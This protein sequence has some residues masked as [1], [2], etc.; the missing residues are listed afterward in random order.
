MNAWKTT[1]LLTMGMLAGIVYATACGGLKLSETGIAMASE[2]SSSSSRA[3]VEIKY[4]SSI[5][6]GLDCEC[7]EGFTNVGGS[8]PGGQ[9]HTV[10]LQD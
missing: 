9:V 1:A 2:L 6:C 5:D 8:A 3:V 7:P 10:C 4:L